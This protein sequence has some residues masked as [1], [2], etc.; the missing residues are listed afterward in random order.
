MIFI[1]ENIYLCIHWKKHWKR[2]FCCLE[3]VQC[4]NCQWI[5]KHVVRWRGKKVAY[6]TSMFLESNLKTVE[7]LLLFALWTFWNNQFFSGLNWNEK[8]DCEFVEFQ[9]ILVYVCHS[10]CVCDITTWTVVK[11]YVE[12]AMHKFILAMMIMMMTMWERYG[13]CLFFVVGSCLFLT[14]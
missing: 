5:L 9:S 8:D 4:L 2:Y 12:R 6:L 11:F 7:R 1:C 13:R 14:L 3:V 10:K